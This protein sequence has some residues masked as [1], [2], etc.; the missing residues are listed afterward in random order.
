MVSSP[1]IYGYDPV[2]NALRQVILAVVSN[3]AFRAVKHGLTKF[4]I[5]R[6]ALSLRG[7]KKTWKTDRNESVDVE[8][9]EKMEVSNESG[10]TLR[11]YSTL[12]LS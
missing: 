2:R 4:P 11:N 10:L 5:Q 3:L 7:R 9:V 6:K 1:S 8:L 12:I